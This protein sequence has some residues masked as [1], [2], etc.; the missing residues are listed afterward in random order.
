MHAEPSEGRY[1][2]GIGG[3]VHV[4]KRNFHRR[5]RRGVGGERLRWRSVD[6]SSGAG[7]RPVTDRNAIVEGYEERIG[8]SIK[9]GCSHQLRG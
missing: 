6:S 4:R 8:V 1:L 9:D 3:L 7:H 5:L 2:E